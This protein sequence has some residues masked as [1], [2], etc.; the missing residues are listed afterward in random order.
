MLERQHEVEFLTGPSWCFEGGEPVVIR[1]FKRGAR[2]IA[3]EEADEEVLTRSK[4]RSL[5]SAL[6]LTEE[7]L[8]LTQAWAE[9]AP[10]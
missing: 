5:C 4:I 3:L 2:R 8:A 6:G 9:G 10:E 1:Y 7:N